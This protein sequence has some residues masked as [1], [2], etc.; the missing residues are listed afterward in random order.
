MKT[1]N[2][3]REDLKDI[4]YY[5]ICKKLIDEVSKTVEN[6]AVIEIIAKYNAAIKVA[7]SRDYV[8]YTSLYIKGLTQESVAEQLGYSPDYV[9]RMHKKLLL[10]LQKVIID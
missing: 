1:L 8:L 9:Q 2:E 5:Y 10:F 3:I 4:R 7:C 6:T